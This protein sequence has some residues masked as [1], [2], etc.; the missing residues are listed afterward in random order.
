MPL[1]TALRRVLW[2]SSTFLIV[3]TYM[4]IFVNLYIWQK[5]A[6]IA[7]V[8]WYNIVMFAAWGVGFTLGA[9]SVTRYATRLPMR[10]SAFSGMAA[11]MLL[12]TL[13]IPNDYL[14][15][16]MVAV[17]AGLFGGFYYAGQNLTITRL[18]QGEEFS[19]F[20]FYQNLVNQVIG[21]VNPIVSALLIHWFGYT[22]SFVLMFLLVCVM[23][24]ISF[25]VPKITYQTA[26]KTEGSFYHH[27]RWREVFPTPSLRVMHAGLFVGGVFFQFQAALALFLT[28]SVTGNKVFIG[29]L[30]MGYTLACVVG[31]RIYQ[32]VHVD[33]KLWMNIGVAMTVVGFLLAI[34]PN[35]TTR[36]VS[37][38]F[39]TVGMFYFGSVWNGQQYAMFS[40]LTPMHSARLFTWRENTFNVARIAVYGAL[41]P[42]HQLTGIPFYTILA[43]M[44][45]SSVFVPYLQTKSLSLALAARQRQI[46]AGLTEHIHQT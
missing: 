46:Q 30:S 10:L 33:K 17:P 20:Y 2:M 19:A 23:F 8:C 32:R 40:A 7:E 44:I 45:V 43:V 22:S 3:S 31:L 41:F 1:P 12:L 39:T 6:S 42:L 27:I 4:G 38:F 14:W 13:H 26:V 11:F 15:I 5:H 18:G 35:Y 16:A 25:T 24:G 37:N 34:F 9:S 36:I 21:L 29:V 28:F